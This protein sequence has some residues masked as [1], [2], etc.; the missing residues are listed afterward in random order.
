MPE[1]IDQKQVEQVAKL[2]RLKLTEPEMA[3]LSIHLSAILE[4]IEKLN[5]LNTDSVEPLA[6]ALG[7]H[8]VFRADVVKPS[9]DP[10]SA[11]AN[12]PQRHE[13]YFKVPKI[14]DDAS[15]A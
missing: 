4:Y 3:Q 10:D 12:A 1:K 2:A 8:N 6:H 9:L 5:E 14:L 7:V 15:G 11:L 13:N